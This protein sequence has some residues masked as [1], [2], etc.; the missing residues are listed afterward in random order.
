MK[1][2]PTHGISVSNKCM[3]YCALYPDFRR[4][5]FWLQKFSLSLMLDILYCPARGTTGSRLALGW[6]I[7]C[8]VFTCAHMFVTLAAPYWIKEPDSELYAPG[9]AVRLECQADGIPTPQITWTI[10]G[11][12]LS[13]NCTG[14]TW[15]WQSLQSTKDDQIKRKRSRRV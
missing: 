11:I 6:N 3:E 12:P 7:Q 15:K 14:F 1:S 13:G 4:Y 10:N 2:G 8:W 9:E 5:R